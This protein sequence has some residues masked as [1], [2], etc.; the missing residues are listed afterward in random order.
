MLSRE[1]E[2]HRYDMKLLIGFFFGL[3]IASAIGQ[4]IPYNLDINAVIAAGVGPDGKMA[5]IKV[6]DEG[7]VICST[8]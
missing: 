7:H 6:D 2:E 4:T 5:S 1:I 3:L 8:K